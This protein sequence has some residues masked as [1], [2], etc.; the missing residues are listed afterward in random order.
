[1][2]E[3]QRKKAS[4]TGNEDGLTAFNLDEETDGGF[5]TATMEPGTTSARR[6]RARKYLCRKVRKAP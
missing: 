1:M 5:A 2:T 6:P 3:D 4:G